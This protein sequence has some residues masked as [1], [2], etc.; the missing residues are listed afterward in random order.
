MVGLIPLF[1]VEILDDEL[2]QSQ[3]KFV[4]RM[5]W[6][7]DN[8]PDLAS[9]VSRWHEKGRNEKHLLSLFADIA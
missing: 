6:F 7:L 5:R 9:L 3:P 2:L 8:R 4:E 1:A